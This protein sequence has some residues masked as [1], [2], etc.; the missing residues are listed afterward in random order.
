MLHITKT[1]YE[2][3]CI[4]CNKEVSKFFIDELEHDWSSSE[5][6]IYYG[7]WE[8]NDSE[9]EV[10]LFKTKGRGDK[11]ISIKNWK[12]Y[13]SINDGVEFYLDRD[14]ELTL[15]IISPEDEYEGSLYSPDFYKGIGYGE[16]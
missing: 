4:D 10:K 5:P 15:S 2:K 6:T 3:S 13:I 8:S 1:M 12:K 11:R 9:L 7:K 16:R 14:N